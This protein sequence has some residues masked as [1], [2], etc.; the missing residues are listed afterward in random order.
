MEV[1]I[2]KWLWAVRLYKTRSLATEACKKGKV[3]VQNTAV[4]PSRMVKPGEVIQIRENPVIYSFKV[5]ALAQ[6]RM[7][8][9]LVPDF[10]ENVTTPDQLQLIE[11]A[12]L[13]AQS[14][15]ARGT[16]RPTK[17]ERRDLDDFVEPFFLDDSDDED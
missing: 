7:N 1:R 14:G 2:D 6:N 11:L 10:M 16:G 15:R 13:A 5:I 4:K 3:L 8:A 12:R 17:K 9:K